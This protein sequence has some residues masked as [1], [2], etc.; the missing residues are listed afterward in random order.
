MGI[1]QPLHRQ[2]QQI[3]D[4]PALV[5]GAD[6]VTYR[7]LL[8]RVA[9][10][11]GALSAGVGVATGDRVGIL[12]L[13]SIR[14]VEVL[15]GTVW[16]GGVVNPVNIRWS[17]AE[18]AYSL[19]DSDTRVL[20]V[21]DAFAPMVPKLR[22]LSESLS[23]VVHFGAGP[24]SED[25]LSWSE[26]LADAEPIPDRSGHG[27]DLAGIFYTGGTTGFPKGVML[28]HTNLLTSCMGGLAATASLR[29]GED[30]CA[31]ISAPLFHIAGF[32]NWLQGMIVGVKEVFL[33][34]FEPK[35]VL[36]AVEKHQVTELFLVPTMIQ[37]MLDHPA[38]AQHDASSIRF[39]TYGASPISEKL[40]ERTMTELPNARLVQAYGQT[41][42]SPLVT[43]LMPEDHEV[44]IP[45]RLRSAGRPV[46]HNAVM[47]IGPDG[48]E[49]ERGVIGEITACGDH[50]MLGY[51]NRPEETAAAI[52]DGWLRSGD[53]GF[54]DEDGYITVVDRLKDMIVTGGENVFSAEVENALSSH[55]A[56]AVC[57]VIGVPDDR[58]GE[59][60]HAVVLTHEDAT[61]SAQELREH[62]QTLIAGYKCPRTVDFVTELPYTAANK[63]AKNVLRDRY[64]AE[65][66][67]RAAEPVAAAATPETVKE[68]TP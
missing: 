3:P 21:D 16:A 32:G 57:A 6:V 52:Q 62:C 37:M 25:T 36:E 53:L 9:H 55:P 43:L 7:E 68:G 67:A 59:R 26:L 40:L 15:A 49:V 19:D 31:L 38:F 39:L 23:T 11:A 44:G 35:A 28:S 20:F 56:V 27:S 10:S 63:I 4:H 45:A 13:N 64:K 51:W 42:L 58:W 47:I 50:V 30:S 17:P 60:V 2:A 66:A 29:Q 24:T 48:R 22:E 54:M 8:G 12:S 33:P 41:E 18:V 1:T 61:A 14:Y 46:V 34:F 5:E 65:A